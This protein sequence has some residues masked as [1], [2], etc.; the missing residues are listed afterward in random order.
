M[1]P[2]RRSRRDMDLIGRRDHAV[3]L[4]FIWVLHFPPPLMTVNIDGQRLFFVHLAKTVARNKT[5]DQ[6]DEK[7][8]NRKRHRPCDSTRCDAIAFGAGRLRSRHIV[9]RVPSSP[10]EIHQR[11]KRQK[12][13]RCGD[14]E[15]Q[16]KRVLNVGRGGSGGIERR[17]VA[18]KAG[19]G[20][21][22]A[23]GFAFCTGC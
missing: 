4:R 7:Q 3:R 2:N 19:N 20:G 13:H 5:A 15:D 9:Q 6:H 8:H 21:Q 23:H 14:P 11:G 17:L 1:N 16:R 22:Q 12:V 10:H 18:G